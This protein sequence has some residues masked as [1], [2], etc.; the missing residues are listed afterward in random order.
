MLRAELE[1]RRLEERTPE[2]LPEAALEALADGTL[3]NLSDRDRSHLGGCLRCLHDY[4]SLRTLVEA[5]RDEG[6]AADRLD[7]EAPAP[8]LSRPGLRARM[9]DTLERL[10]RPLAVRVPAG[11]AAVAMTA[12]VVLT[13]L[14][15]AQP[16][17]T[18]LEVP[19]VIEFS[20]ARGQRT[21]TGIVRGIEDRSTSDAMAHL[22]HVDD[23]EGSAFT[24]FSWG[25]PAVAV[26]D[27]VEIVGTFFQVDGRATGRVY[28]GVASSV[29]RS[30]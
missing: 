16:W 25:Q 30:R 23:A 28:Q 15:T 1:R 20:T 24:V 3:G 12:A 27:Q 7:S 8:G 11:W 9:I 6:A 2:C 18:P 5:A 26:G 14:A 29:R 4:A 22:L 17:R 19:S 10:R 21:V 13:W